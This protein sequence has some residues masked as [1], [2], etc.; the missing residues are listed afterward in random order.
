MKKIV[1]ALVALALAGIV[2]PVIGIISVAAALFLAPGAAIVAAL[3][4][5]LSQVESALVAIVASIIVSTHF[6]YWLSVAAGYSKET[7]G[8]AV[9]LLCLP[10]LAA[11]VDAKKL[12]D[13]ARQLKPAVGIALLFFLLLAGMYHNNYWVERDG[14]VVVGGWNWSDL[15]VHLPIA[16][17]VNEG[18]FPPQTP[19]YA[20]EK[21]SYH[22]FADFHS[23]VAAK[24]FG[25][26]AD[27]IIGVMRLENSLY[28]AIFFLLCFLLAKR[29]AKR[30]STAL[31]AAVL[32]VF[33]GG[34]AYAKIIEDVA[35]GGNVAELLKNTAY[36][37]DWKYFQVPSVMGGYLLVQR[38]QMV[39]LAA[40]ASVMLLCVAARQE[41]EKKLY[42]MAG[43]VAGLLAPFQYFAFAASLFALF[44]FIAIEAW[45]KKRIEAE[46]FFSF[47]PVVFSLPFAL[48]AFSSTSS[49]G[50]VK[51]LLGWLAPKTP[52]E[53][54][55]FYFVN[56]GLPF[57]LALAALFVV[58][59]EWKKQL[60]AVG[61]FGFLLP[62]IVALS[63]TVWDMGKFFTYMWVPIG[64]LAAMALENKKKIV[65]AAAIALSVVT[66]LQMFYWTASSNWQAFSSEELR[67]GEWIAENTPQES[68]FAT[69]NSHASPVDAVG[70]R[71]RLLGYAGWMANYGFGYQARER[72]VAKAY[73]G[74]AA[75]RKSAFGEM[76]ISFLYAGPKEREAYK[77][78]YEKT[79]LV[80]KVFENE[81]VKIYRVK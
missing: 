66:P 33:G 43:V 17:T 52:L 44:A 40:L 61:A 74:S 7:V 31:I 3:G 5:K 36:D 58:K 69:S 51:L 78:D 59:S 77:C 57:I 60:V 56:L 54:V 64:V 80:Q 4:K 20:G 71:L 55:G 28:P 42:W 41:K 79:G 22:F 21:L 10:L 6:A 68:V 24:Y 18:N 39:G 75:E 81:A 73:C 14:G 11:R 15:F 48:S 32:I 50:N 53:F 12:F 16:R 26:G 25:G 63:G 35:N 38:P 46:N 76:E 19:F 1:A 27:A 2:F 34:F 8:I 37:N 23:A 72:V 47:A 45:E 65:V 70:G 49:A 13:E 29:I 9:A 62:N 67:A 30:N